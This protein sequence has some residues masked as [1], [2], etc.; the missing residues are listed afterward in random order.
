MRR[1]RLIITITRAV[2]QGQRAGRADS[3]RSL[4]PF[5]P[6]VTLALPMRSRGFVRCGMSHQVVAGYHQSEQDWMAD[7]QFISRAQASTDAP[8]KNN[9]SQFSVATHL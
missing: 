3:S 1:H 2:I 7:P 5:D 8:E 4:L 6:R 9:R